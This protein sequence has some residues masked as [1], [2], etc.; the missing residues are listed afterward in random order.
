MLRIVTDVAQ[1]TK[2]AASV[3]GATITSGVAT[4]MEWIPEYIGVL[5]TLSGLVLSIVLIVTHIKK[6]KREEEK[7]KIEMKILESKIK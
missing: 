7:H 1:S 5:A 4:V 6:W 2:T 3:S